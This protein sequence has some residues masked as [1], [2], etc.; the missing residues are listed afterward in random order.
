MDARIVVLLIVV[1]VLTWAFGADIVES[2]EPEV[3]APE[4][5]QVGAHA[6]LVQELPDNRYRHRQSL[7]N[8]LQILSEMREVEDVVPLSTGRD[9]LI[10]VGEEAKHAAGD[11]K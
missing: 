9:Y 4:T 6:Y 8:Q 7:V 3:P 11:A 5:I 10:F 2:L 1:V